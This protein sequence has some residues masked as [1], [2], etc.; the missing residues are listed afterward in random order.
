LQGKEFRQS[1]SIFTAQL[2]EHLMTTKA[3]L[4]VFS[5]LILTKT[6]AQISNKNELEAYKSA[7]NAYVWGFPLVTLALEIDDFTRKYTEGQLNV[8]GFVNSNTQE[9]SAKNEHIFYSKAYLDLKNGPLLVSL[10]LNN[11]RYYGLSLNDAFGNTFEVYG[12]LKNL[13]KEKSILIVGPDWNGTTP[14]GVKKIMKSP[15][16]LAWVEGYISVVDQIDLLEG[17]KLLE[18]IKI[19]KVESTTSEK[20]WQERHQF[21]KVK[22]LGNA[23]ERALAM[24]WKTYFGYISQMLKENKV[25]ENQQKYVADFE[26]LGVFPGKE[27]EDAR[28]SNKKQKGIKQGFADAIELLKIEA[29][30][31]EDY[32]KNGW[33]YNVGEGKWAARYM[34]NAA[35]AFNG[36]NQTYAEEIMKYKTRVDGT[37]QILNGNA[38]YKLTLKKIQLPQTKALWTVNVLQENKR[39]FENPKSKYGVGNKTKGLKYNKDGSL[40]LYFQKDAPKGFEANWVPTPAENFELVFKVFGPGENVISGEWA[41]PAVENY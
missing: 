41:P 3:F 13:S 22:A 7:Y 15:T 30:R 5:T 6:S 28:V 20:S 35:S 12:S 2:H 34:K 23:T 25:P 19:A 18:T 38:K 21:F 1:D 33:S 11:L 29:P 8:F 24:D 16:N 37:K 4:I 36:F 17:K 32:Y 40:T 27:F 39:P 26:D 9:I 10:P 31:Q 14:K